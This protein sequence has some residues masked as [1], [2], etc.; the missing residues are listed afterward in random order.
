MYFEVEAL[1]YALEAL[2]PFISKT[3]VEFHYDKH[4]K[5]YMKKLRALLENTVEAKQS[6]DSIVRSSSGEVFNNAAQVY[7]H[8]FFWN[9]MK[10]QGGGAPPAGAML[11]LLV[12]DFGSWDKF[13]TRFIQ[14]G[15]ER[16]GS[17]WVW[18]VVE[19]GEGKIVSTADASTPLT[20]GAKPLLVADVWEHAYY[21]DYQNRRDIYLSL[22]CDKLINWDFALYNLLP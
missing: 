18:L 8:T 5:G 3:T 11:D 15:L 9:S 1:P 22:F 20:T 21:L 6:L 2:E 16:F 19:A 7:N 14:S 13:R 10:P 17:G 4:Q 12:R